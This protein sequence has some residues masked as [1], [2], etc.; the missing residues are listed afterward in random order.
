MIDKGWNV[1]VTSWENDGDCYNTKCVTFDNEK[2][3]RDVSSFLYKL[4]IHKDYD[5]RLDENSQSSLAKLGK[6][7]ISEHKHLFNTWELDYTLEDELYWWEI[8]TE[9]LGDF[10]GFSSNPDCCLRVIED[11]QLIYIP[12]DTI[13]RETVGSNL[14][15]ERYVKNRQ[16]KNL[17]D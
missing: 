2:D 13:Y 3:A 14:H 15:I 16:E 1:I 12:I 17:N 4:A 6:S 11:I 7:F 5:Q 8:F 9:F 10:T